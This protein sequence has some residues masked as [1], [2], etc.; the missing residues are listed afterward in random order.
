MYCFPVQNVC[1]LHFLSTEEVL[2]TDEMDYITLCYLF[3]KG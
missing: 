2:I 3:L 1:N